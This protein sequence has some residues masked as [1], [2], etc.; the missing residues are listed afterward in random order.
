MTDIFDEVAEELRAERTRQL[1]QRYAGVLI[2][3][4]LLAVAAVAGWQAWRW[5]EARQD[6]IAATSYMNAMMAAEATGK[7]AAA[8]HKRALVNLDAL[9]QT[10]PDGYRTLA[11]L[12]AAALE[13]DDGDLRGALGLWN[14]VA[15][16]SAADP[17]LRGLATLLWAQHQ[18]DSGNPGFVR[19]R[20]TVLAVPDNPWHALAKEQLALLDLREG[21]KQAARHTLT[22]L[23][24]DP[25]APAGVRE[26]ATAVLA[27]ING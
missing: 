8:A 26:R 19:G 11:R 9:A 15:A 12:R 2:G 4:A 7:D 10:A 17:V 27:E 20:L 6:R 16:D 1:L 24:K 3:A 14:A 18:I 25:T 23:S 5:Y 21:K 22:T 13:A